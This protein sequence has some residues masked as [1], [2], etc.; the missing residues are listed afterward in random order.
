MGCFHG[1]CS[2]V[3]ACCSNGVPPPSLTG[4]TPSATRQRH[5]TNRLH[6][7]HVSHGGPQSDPR[8]TAVISTLLPLSQLYFAGSKLGA[9]EKD[10]MAM[11]TQMMGCAVR[12]VH[13]RYPLSV[14]LPPSTSPLPLLQGRARLNREP[15]PKKI[16]Q[17]SPKKRRKIKAARRWP[18]ARGAV[19]TAA[20]AGLRGGGGG[21]LGGR[22]SHG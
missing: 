2:C 8:D 1:R 7:A 9:F 15:T 16:P 12:C 22:G 3:R 20:A 13:I 4:K 21:V 11:L 6:A 18:L 10:R 5:A 17:K 19:A 14:S